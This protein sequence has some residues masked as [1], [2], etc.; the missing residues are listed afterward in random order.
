MATLQID[1][2]GETLQRLRHI[3]QQENRALGEVAAHLLANAVRAVRLRPAGDAAEAELLRQINTG[4]DAERWQR[5]HALVAQR[6]AGCLTPAEHR[7]LL[8]LT[9][10]RERAHAQRL[11]HLLAL[12]TL[13][14]TTLDAVMEE[15]G[16]QAPG[17]D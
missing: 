13:R 2:D 7:E 5:Y 6:R 9:D 1:L 4:W 12:A 8:A 16:L 15:L 14:Q 10:E 17:Y 11:A 3:S